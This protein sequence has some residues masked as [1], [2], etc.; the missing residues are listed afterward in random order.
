M[1]TTSGAR[2]CHKLG[3]LSP[4]L[5]RSGKPANGACTKQKTTQQVNKALDILKP[6]I[7][8]PQHGF[9]IKGQGALPTTAMQMPMGGAPTQPPPP[10]PPAGMMVWNWAAA[11]WEWKWQ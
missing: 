7:L 5:G 8:G 2:L 11:T 9:G 6:I 3:Q 1:T 10:Q 4:K